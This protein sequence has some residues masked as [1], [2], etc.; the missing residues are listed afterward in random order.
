MKLL[1]RKYLFGIAA[2]LLSINTL[3]QIPERPKPER[4]VN[5]YV[6]LLSSQEA[7][8]LEREL[9]AFND[10]TSNQIVVVIVKEIVG[11][12]NQM[13]Y[14]IGHNWGVGQKGK[15]N[16]IVILVKPKTSLSKGEVAIQSGYG[17][18]GVV[19]DAICKRIVE[20]E[21]IPHFKQNDYFGGITAAT[22]VLMKLTRGEFTADQYDKKHKSGSTAQLVI[23]LIVILIVI[24]SAFRSRRHV[25]NS[26]SIGGGSVPF[27]LLMSMMGSSGRSSGGSYSDFSSGGGDFGGFGGGDFGGGG[28]GGSW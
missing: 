21:M 26:Q 16:G 6:G 5:D 10:S 23:V 18:E 17:L 3:A 1:S 15:N 20:V 7:N 19:P 13:A 25:N 11:D 8:Q 22:S 24:I 2:L 28:A 27:W 4:L 9:V 12:K 14:E